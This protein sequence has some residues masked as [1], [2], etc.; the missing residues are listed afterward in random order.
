MGPEQLK[1]RNAAVC[2]P[3]V[4]GYIFA[5]RPARHALALGAVLLVAALSP[6]IHGKLLERQRSFFG[7]HRVT[8]DPTGHFRQLVHG[9]TIH[10]RQNIDPALKD[11]PLSYYHRKGPIGQVFTYG[12]QAGIF[13]R[14]GIVGLGAGT[15]AAYG[16]PGQTMTYF[17]IDPV[18]KNIAQNQDLFTFLHDSKANMN[19]V[20]GD[21]RLTL[22][23]IPDGSLDLLVLDAFTSDAIPMHLM[24]LQ[25]FQ[26][27]Q[28]KLTPDG[29][30]A[31]NISN[32][33]LDLEPVVARLARELH[34]LCWAQ[35]MSISQEER[36]QGMSDSQWMLLG[37]S[38]PR[39]E[40]V[41][42]KGYWTRAQ[43]KPATPLWTDDFSNLLSVVKW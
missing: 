32:R 39:L 16:R 19:I 25:A 18:V 36:D 2:L 33:Y 31:I 24:T 15:L 6:G 10:G 8:L 37:P 42:L 40:A 17:E 22:A 3:V 43:F 41:A 11:E 1:L 26:M 27:Y 29:T 20:L 5:P 7:I 12:N 23:D 34:W 28:R 9:N 21:A 14:V 13:D 4:L 30:L 38:S 35:F